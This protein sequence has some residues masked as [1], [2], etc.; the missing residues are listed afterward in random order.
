MLPTTLQ[1]S[2]QRTCAALL[3]LQLLLLLPT[4]V[5]PSSCCHPLQHTRKTILLTLHSLEKAAR[6]ARRQPQWG[7][8]DLPDC[9]NTKPAQAQSRREGPTRLTTKPPAFIGEAVQSVWA[10]SREDTS[11]TREA[12]AAASVLSPGAARCS[13]QLTALVL[14]QLSCQ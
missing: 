8:V 11:G 2:S 7:L 5:P 13:K 12:T 10:V 1:D 14:A 3:L 4:R 9:S 6:H